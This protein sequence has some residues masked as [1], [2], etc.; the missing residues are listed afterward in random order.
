MIKAISLT[1]LIAAF[2]FYASEYIQ[3][4]KLAINSYRYLK[5]DLFDYIA[6]KL[7]INNYIILKNYCRQNYFDFLY[8]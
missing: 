7:Y 5:I 8:Y 4:Y 6:K 1:N 3:E 2:N